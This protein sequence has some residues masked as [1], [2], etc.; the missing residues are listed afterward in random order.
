VN[1]EASVFSLIFGFVAA[2]VVVF[3]LIATTTANKKKGEPV[4]FT[5]RGVTKYEAETKTA[6]PNE[7]RELFFCC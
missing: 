5:G 6:A 1:R 3:S 7:R 4:V 2:V